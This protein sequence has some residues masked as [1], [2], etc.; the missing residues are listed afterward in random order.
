MGYW[1]NEAESPGMTNL[2]NDDE[3]RPNEETGWSWS[4]LGV[5]P[6]PTRHGLP[7]RLQGVAQGCAAAAVGLILTF[8]FGKRLIGGFAV[9]VGLCLAFL[10]SC[11]PTA[12]AKVNQFFACLG[13]V[14]GSLLTCLLLVPFF[15]L[16]FVPGRIVLWIARRDPMTRDWDSS[17]DSYWTLRDGPLTERRYDRQY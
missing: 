12:F 10:A 16:C 13:R 1:S 4:G 7:H 15:F 2:E 9:L 6:S 11:S 8:G 3:L 14:V 17:S 5:A